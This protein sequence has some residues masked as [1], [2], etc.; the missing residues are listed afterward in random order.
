MREYK[1]GVLLREDAM[2]PEQLEAIFGPSIQLAKKRRI[3][4]GKTKVR[5]QAVLLITARLPSNVAEK[6]YCT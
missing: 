3:R 1:D 4:K 6:D 2:P 5:E